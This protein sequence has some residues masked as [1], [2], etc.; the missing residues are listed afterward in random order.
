MDMREA[1]DAV[2]YWAVLVAALSAFVAGGLWYSV[3]FAK[4]WMKANGF[5]E[6]ELK[7]SNMGLIFGGS[8]VLALAIAYILALFLGPDR[9]ASMGATAG[10]MAG[11]FWVAAA[12]GITY[13][14]ERKPLTLF[15]VNAGYH[16]VTFTLMGLILGAWK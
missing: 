1:M 6:Q 3:L 15:F 12:F 11:L 10:L 8:F 9:D 4:I 16:V 14:F 5:T 7:K 2:N 13:L